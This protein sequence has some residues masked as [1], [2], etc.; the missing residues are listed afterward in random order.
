RNLPGDRQ[1][2]L[3]IMLPLVNS[4]EQVASDIYCLVGRIYKDMF[5]DSHFIDIDSRDQGI[6]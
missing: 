4:D 3:D 6:R 2:A 1:K 5:L